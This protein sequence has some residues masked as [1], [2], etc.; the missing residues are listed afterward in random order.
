MDG[1]QFR[2]EELVEPLRTWKFVHILFYVL[3]I[4]LAQSN[5]LYPD[6]TYVPTYGQYIAFNR[7]VFGKL[8]FKTNKIRITIIFQQYDDVLNGTNKP[9]M[10]NGGG[11]CFEFNP[12]ELIAKPLVWPASITD[13]VSDNKTPPNYLNLDWYNQTTLGIDGNSPYDYATILG[14]PRGLVTGLNL[15]LIPL[16]K[17]APNKAQYYTEKILQVDQSPKYPKLQ[18][19]SIV[20]GKQIGRASCRERV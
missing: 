3:A 4:Y 15:V 12:W 6:Q 13:Y 10:E 14:P 19:V 7:G 5:E 16:E 2:C 11:E 20:T 8:N 17:N 18:T 1:M 9:Y